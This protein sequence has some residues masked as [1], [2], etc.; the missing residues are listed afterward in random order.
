[1]KKIS[2][3]Q[4]EDALNWANEADANYEFSIWLGAIF[5]HLK[6]QMRQPFEHYYVAQFKQRNLWTGY[7]LQLFMAIFVVVFV[8]LLF[9]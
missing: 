2:S 3:S 1:M 6:N 5:Y 8:F 7:F 9:A 4:Q